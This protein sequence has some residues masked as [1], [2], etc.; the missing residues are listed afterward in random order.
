MFRPTM[1]KLLNF[2]YFHH[3]KFNKKMNIKTLRKL[4]MQSL[5]SIWKAFHEYGC[6]KAIYT[7]EAMV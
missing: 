5:A 1:Q 3:Y 6:I 4:A 7:F 2:E